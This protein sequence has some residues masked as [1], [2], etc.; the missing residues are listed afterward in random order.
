[1]MNPIAAKALAIVVGV[2]AVIA[3][4]LEHDGANA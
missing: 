2:A 3:V 4:Q 1:M